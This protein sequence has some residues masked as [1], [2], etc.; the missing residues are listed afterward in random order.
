M[1]SLAESGSAIEPEK[2]KAVL[3]DNA[4]KF[5]VE[6]LHPMYQ[7]LSDAS[8]YTLITDW[9]EMG[10]DSEKKLAHKKYPNGEIKILVISKVMSDDGKRTTEKAPISEKD[11]IN[12]VTGSVQ[13]LE[14]TRYEFEYIQ[15]AITFRINYDQFAHS[16]LRILEVDAENEDDRTIFDVK[17]FPAELSEVTGDMQYYGHRVAAVV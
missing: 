1:T 14:K 12:L 6:S 2:E 17:D 4:R 7:A 16:Q 8:A 15:N 10:K 11:Y 3:D 13:R 5:V 9:L